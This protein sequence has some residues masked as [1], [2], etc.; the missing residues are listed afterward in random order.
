MA[1]IRDSEIVQYKD[2]K[3][4]LKQI[5][6]QGENISVYVRPGDEVD[7]NLNGINLQDLQYKLVG[8]D[9]I[10]DIPNQGSFTFVSM[11][12]M[13]YSDTPPFFNLGGATKLTL[14]TILSAIEEVNDLPLESVSASLQVKIDQEAKEDAP[15]V[16]KQPIVIIQEV[17]VLVEKEEQEPNENIGQFTDEPVDIPEIDPVIFT[18]TET[19]SKSSTE[20]ETKTDDGNGVPALLTFDIDIQHIS[21]TD[22][23]TAGVM[24]VE[25]G[26]GTSYDNFYPGTQAQAYKNG[27]GLVKQGD[28]EIIDYRNTTSNEANKL[29]INADDPAFFDTNIISREIVLSP[30]QPIGFGVTSVTIASDSFPVD[31]DIANSTSGGNSFTLVKDDLD[32]SVIEGF[33]F[34]ASGN[35][36]IKILMNKNQADQNFEF[37]IDIVSEFNMDN[38][39]EDLKSEVEDITGSAEATLEATK[40]YG[41]NVKNIPDANIDNPDEYYFEEFDDSN[42]DKIESG[43]VIITNDNDNIIY[44][45]KT[46]E[47]TINGGVANDLITTGNQNDTVDGRDGTDTMD[48]SSN[49][50]LDNDFGIDANL[51]TGI[52]TK[53]YAANNTDTVLNIENV[54]GTQDNDNIVGSADANVL[55]GEAGNDT[56]RGLAGSDT[57][58]G[59]AG[60]DTLEGGAAADSIN[61]GAGNDTASYENATGDVTVDLDNGNGNGEASGADGNDTLYN[62]ENVKGSAHDDT[63]TGD[64]GDNTLEGL[65]GDDH[66]YVSAGTDTIDGGSNG[67]NGD[68]ID[69]SNSS[70]AHTISLK[71]GQVFGEGYSS[72][73]GV[74]NAIGSAGKDIIVGNDDTNTLQGGINEDTIYGGAG[75]DFIYGG[76]Q[77]DTLSGGVGNDYINGGSSSLGGTGDVA[78]YSDITTGGVTVDLRIQDGTTSQNTVNAGNDTLVDIENLTGTSF[79]DTL[80]GDTNDNTLLGGSG[81]DTFIGNGST[82][83]GDFIDGEGGTDDLISFETATQ[84]ITFD[85]G[86][87]S[88]YQSTG[89]GKI[90]VQN[91]ENLKGGTGADTLY[92]SSQENKLYGHDGDDFLDGKAGNDTLYGELGDDTLTGGA[93]DDILDG[94]AGAD[95]AD[96]TANTSSGIKVDLT[97]VTGQVIDDGYGDTDTL[98]DIERVNG[99]NFTDTI[100]G[101][102]NVD[103]LYGMGGDDTLNGGLGSDTLYGGLGSDTADY[104]TRSESIKVDLSV[105]IPTV[106]VDTNSNSTFESGVDEEDTLNSI[107]NIIGGTNADII[108][109][110]SGNNTLKGNS[111]ADTLSGGIGTD[112]LD[113]GDDIDTIDFSSVNEDVTIDLSKTVTQAVYTD[114]Y[115]KVSNIENIIGGFGADKLTGDVQVNTIIG[116]DGADTLDGGGVSG[117]GTDSLIGGAGDDNFVVSAVGSTVYDG[118]FGAGGADVDTADFSKIANQSTDKVN[119]NLDSG[120][121]TLNG[122]TIAGTT[123]IGIEGAIGGSGDDTIT[124]TTTAN[125]LVGGAGD[126]TLLGNGASSGIDYIDGGEGGET[127]GDFVSFSY[128]SSNISVDLSNS[129]VQNSGDGNLIIQNI[130]NLEGGSGDDTLKGNDDD[131]I[132]R[133]LTG[134]DTLVGGKGYDTL[135]GG[136]GDIDIADYSSNTALGIKVDLTQAAQVTNDGYNNSD[137]LIDIEEIHGSNFTD[138]LVGAGDDD[139]FRGGAGDDTLSGASGADTLYG[140]AGN[141]VLKGGLGDDTLDGGLDN[142]TAD[143]SDRSEAIYG[144][145]SAATPNVIVDTDDANSDGDTT[146]EFDGSDEVDTLNAIENI[147]GGSN[148]DTLIGDANANTLSGG[149]G[150]DTLFGGAGADKLIG[151]DGSD[152]VSYDGDVSAINISL[153]TNQGIDGSGDTDSYNSIENVI[154]TS[155]DDTIEGDSSNNTLDG[156][157]GKDAISYANSTNV[158]G[159]TVNLGTQTASGVDEGTDTILNFEDILGGSGNDTL[160]GDGGTNTITGGSGNDTLDGAAGSDKLVGGLGSD[161]ASYENEGSLVNINLRA[162][163]G[164]DSSGGTDSY[165]SIEN[166]IGSDYDDTIEGNTA[167]NVLQGGL[168]NDT[169]TFENALSGVTVNLG[170]TTQQNTGSDGQDTIS[171]FENL[172]GSSSADNLTG[173]DNTNIIRGNG[174]DDSLSGG[175]GVDSLYGGAGNDTF[176]VELGDGDDIIDGYEDAQTDTDDSSNKDTLDYSLLTGNYYANVDLSLNSAEVTDGTTTDQTDTI[177][178]IENVIGSNQNDTL[179]GNAEVNTLSGSSG[180]DTFILKDG[181]TTGDAI[182]GGAHTIDGSGTQGST[183]AYTGKGDTVDYSAVTQSINLTLTNGAGTTNVQVGATVADHTLSGIENIIGSDSSDDTITGNTA[184]NTILGMAGNDTIDG[185]DGADILDGGFTDDGGG[186]N[187]QTNTISFASSTIGVTANLTTGITSQSDII[188]NFTNIIGTDEAAQVDILTGDGQDNKIEGLAGNDTIEGLDGDDNLLGGAGNDNFILRADDGEDTIDGG[189]GSG[190]TLD[191]SNLTSTQ[192]LEIEIDTST[193]KVATVREG[194]TT[195]TDDV[196]NIENITGGAGDDTITGDA[197]ENT[198]IG[199]AGDDILDGDFEDDKLYGG[200]GDDQLLGGLGDD[201]LYGE[202]GDDLLSGGA[203]DDII[204]GGETAEVSGDTIDYSSKATNL[205]LNLMNVVGGYATATLGTEKDSLA[206]IENIIGTINDDYIGGDNDSNALDGRAGADIIVGAGGDDVLSGGDDNDTFK[207]GLDN[208]VLAGQ[209]KVLEDGD[210]GADTIDGGDEIDTVDYS[211]ISQ[212]IEVT[213][214]GA[215]NTTV[216]VGGAGTGYADD[217]IKNVENVIGSSGND[218]INGDSLDNIL[219]G[220]AG[221]DTLYGAGGNDTLE[222]GTGINTADY[223]AALNKIVVDMDIAAGEVTADGDGGVDNLNNIQKIIATTN[224]DTIYGS[225]NDELFIGGADTDTLM[226]RGGDDTLY[227]GSFDGTNRTDSANDTV[228]YEYLTNGTD[229]VVVD[230]SADTGTAVVSTGADTDTLYDIENIIGGAGDDTIITRFDE[231]NIINGAA[232]SDTIDYSSLDTSH[233]ISVTLGTNGAQSTVDVSGT[234]NDDLVE[235][236]ENVTGTNLTDSIYGNNL[237]NTLLGLGGDDTLEGGAGDD[238]LDGGTDGANGDTA[239]YNQATGSVTVDLGKDNIAQ[240][241]GGGQGTDT[242]VDIENVIGSSY[243]DTFYTNFTEV[244]NFD[245]GIEDN[246]INGDTVDYSNLKADVGGANYTGTAN[247]DNIFLDLTSNTVEVR[248]GGSTVTDTISNIENIIATSG[249]DTLYGD[250]GD[251]TLKGLL[252]DDILDGGQGDDY[253]DGGVAGSDTAYYNQATSGVTVDLGL[254]GVAQA[255][256]GNQGTDTLV[257]IENVIGSKYNDTFKGDN[258]A[259]NIFNGGYVLATGVENVSDENDTVDYSSLT[260]ATDKIVVDLSNTTTPNV[261]VTVATTLQG[262]DTLI[263]IENVTGSFG[264]DTF[265][266]NSDSNV[267]LG[268]DGDDT[269][270]ITSASTG[271]EVDIINGGANSSVGDTVDFSGVTNPNYYV[272]VN[273]ASQDLLLKD[274]SNNIVRDDTVLN[275]ENITGTANEDIIIGDSSNNILDGDDGT[276]SISGGAGDDIIYGGANSAGDGVGVYETLDGGADN[277]TIYGGAGNDRILGGSGIGEDKLYGEAG[278][279]SITG[280]SGIDTIDGGADNDTIKG[281][282]GE[283]ILYGGTEDDIIYGGTEGDVIYGDDSLNSAANAGAD[284]LF[285]EDGTDTLFGG[286]GDDTLI[287]GANNDSL[288]GGEGTDTVDFST[289]GNGVTVD[290][291]AQTALGDGTD[292][293]NSIENAIGSTYDDNF[294]SDFAVSNRF[295]G[296]EG[297]ETTGDSISYAAITV[298]GGVDKVVVDLSSGADA[299]GYYDA[300][301]YQDGVITNTDKLKNMENITGSDGDDTI[302]GDIDNNTLTGLDGD[303][304]LSGQGGDDVLIGGAGSDTA[305]YSEKSVAVTV[306][307]KTNEATTA[308]ETDSLNSIENAIGGTA[309]DTFKMNEDTTANT[310]DG[311]GDEDTIS[312][313]YYTSEGVDVNLSFTG[314][315]TVATGDTD[316]IA[317]IEHIIG[318]SKNDTFV[319]TTASNSIVGG[320]GNDTFIAG[321]DTDNDNVIENVDDGADYIDGGVGTGDWAD[322]SSIGDDA[323]GATNGIE[324]TL[325]GANEVTATVNGQTGDDTLLN[326]ENISGTQDSDSIKGDVQNNTLLGNAGADILSGEAGMDELYGGDDADTLLGGAGD[327]ILMGDAGDDTLTGGVGSDN[328]Y[329]GDNSSDSGVDTVDYT[330]A[331]ES[332]TIDL[333]VTDAIGLTQ[334]GSEEGRSDGATGDQGQGVDNLYGIENVIGSNFAA[335][336]IYGS[337]EANIIQTQ[338]GDDTIVAAGA[339][340][341][342]DHYDGGVGTDTLDYSALS[343][344]ITIDLSV[345]ATDDFDGAGGNDSWS[346]SIATG[347][348]DIIKN[349]EN[350]IGGSGDDIITMNSGVNEIQG[351]AGSDT[352]SGNLGNDIINGYYE[353]QDEETDVG[354]QYDTVSYSYL[355]TKSVVL[356]LQLGTAYVDASDSDTLISIENAIGGAQGDTLTGSTLIN[357]LEGGAGDDTFVSSLG[358]DFIFGGNMASGTHTD[359]HI[360]GDTVDYSNSVNTNNK[361]VVDL[362]TTANDGNVYSN[363]QVLLDSDNSAV[364]TDRLYGIENISGTQNDDTLYGNSEANTLIGNSGD[365]T[366]KGGLG[367]DKLDG[368]AGD[369]IFLIEETDIGDAGGDEI[370]GGSGN[371]T[372]NYLGITSSGVTVNLETGADVTIGGYTHEFSG[373]EHI[374]GTNQADILTGDI[375]LNRIEGMGGDDTVYGKYGDDILDGGVGLDTLYGSDGLDTLYG[376]DDADKLYGG[377]GLDTIFGGAGADEIIF[378]AADNQNDIVYGGDASSDTSEDDLIDYTTAI[379]GMTVTLGEDNLLGTATSQDQGT[380]DIYGIEHVKGSNI[381]SDTIFGNSDVNTLYGQGADDTLYGKD[382][383]DH[384]LGGDQDDVLYGDDAIGN[385]D[386][387]AADTLDGGTGDDTLYGGLGDDELIGG[388]GDDIFKAVYTTDIFDGDDNIDGG[389]DSDTIDYSAVVDGQYYGNIDLTAGSVI[390]YD[391][392]NGDAVKKTDSITSIENA[393]GTSGDDTFKGNA[394]RNTLAGRSGADTVMYTFAALTAGIVADLSADTVDKVTTSGTFTDTVTQIENIV[395]TDF[396][397]VFVGA[398]GEVN[399]I[400]GGESTV[401]GQGNEVGGDTVDYSSQSDAIDVT[402]NGSTLVDVVISGDATDQ[403][404]NIE[405]VTG[406]TANDTIVGDLSVNTLLGMDGNDNLDGGAGND[407]IDGGA[408]DDIITG[409]A[410]IDTLYGGTGDDTFNQA[411]IADTGDTIDGGDGSDTVDYSGIETAETGG[412]YAD[413]ANNEILIDSNTDAVFDNSVDKVDTITSI[414][415]VSGTQNNDTLLGN[416]EVNELS[417]NGG[418]DYIDGAIG[419]DTLLGGLGDDEVYGGEGIDILYG[420]DIANSD[421]TGGDDTLSGGA[422]EDT[423]YGG[424]GDDTLIGGVNDDKLKGGEGSDTADY[425]GESAAVQANIA[426]SFAVGS[427]S[428]TDTFESIENITGTDLGGASDQITGDDASNTLK[429]LAGDDTISELAGDDEVVGGAGDD[430][431]YAGAGAD[432]IDGD[433]TD[434]ATLNGTS[435]TLDYS[436]INI[437]DDSGDTRDVDGTNDS[438]TPSSDAYSGIEIDLTVTT[439][440]RI[441]AQYGTDTVTNIENIV[442]SGKNDYIGGNDV[443]NTLEGRS[444]ND[445]LVGLDGADKLIGGDGIDT[446]DFSTGVQNVV[447]DMTRTQTDGSSGTYRVQNDGYGHQEYLDGVENITTGAGNDTIYGDS[448]S[449]TIITGAGNDTIRGGAQADVIEGG[450]DEDTVDFSDLTYGVTV[451]LDTDNNSGTAADGTA[452]SNGKTD[453]IREI[454]NVIGTASNDIIVA[455]EKDNTLIGADGDDTF[456][457]LEGVDYIDGGAGTNDTIDFSDG[458]QGIQVDL[459]AIQTFGTNTT[460]IVQDDGFG[461]KE[462]INGIENIIGTNSADT[463]IGDSAN[464]KFEGGSNDDTLYGDAGDDTLIGGTGADTFR[465]G[466]GN[467]II[468]GSDENISSSDASRDVIDYSDVNVAMTINLDANQ[469]SGVGQGVDLIYDIQDVLGSSV[470]DTITGI[471]DSVNSLMGQ[472]GDD[473][474]YATLDGDFIYGGSVNTTTSVHTDSGDDTVDYSAIDSNDGRAINVDL[475]RDD[476]DDTTNNEQEVQLV[477]DNTKFDNLE[478]IENIIGTQNNDIIKGS[479]DATEVNTLDGDKGD[480]TFFSSDGV[481]SFIGGEGI[482]TL[483]F[484]GVNTGAEGV[485]VDLDQDKAIDDGFGLED[486]IANDIEVVI[487]STNDDIL[488]GDSADNTLLG[489]DGADTIEGGSGADS[490]EGGVGVDTL[491]GD[492]GNDTILGGADGDFLYGGEG[493]D[494]LDGE[495]GDDTIYFDKGNDV[496][497]GGTGA[498][499]LTYEEQII[500]SSGI[501]VNLEATNGEVDVGADGIDNLQ[502]H[503]ETIIGTG[504]DDNFNG[505]TGS[506]AG[507]YV[508]TFKGL[509][510]NDVFSG[511][512]GDDYLDGGNQV[513]TLIFTNAQ[514]GVNVDLS[515]T[516]NL[517][518]TNTYAVQDDGFGDQDYV[519]NIENIIGTAYVDT[520]GGD[521]N[522][523]SIAAGDNDDT[524]LLSTGLDTL[525]GESGSDWISLENHEV[526]I[527]LLNATH[528]YAVNE[529]TTIQNI[530]NIIDST[531]STATR[532]MWGT[533]EGNIVI[534]YDGNDRVYG[535]D[536]DDVVDLGAGD[537]I[538]YSNERDATNAIGTGTDTLMGGAGTDIL[539]FRNDITGG[540]SA[541]IILQTTTFDSNFD[542]TNETTLT[543][544]TTTINLSGLDSYT[545][546]QNFVQITD[547][548]G[549]TDYIYVDGSGNTDFEQFNLSYA[550]DTFVGDDAVNIVNA[551]EGN[552]TI[553]GMGG[554]D[555]INGHNGNDKIYGGEGNDV[556]NAGNDQDTIIGGLGDDA[557]NGGNGNDIIYDDEGTDTIDG[558]GGTDTVIFKDGGNGITIDLTA[559]TNNSIDSYGNTQNIREVENVTSTDYVDTITTNSSTNVILAGAQNDTIF[560]STGND[561]INGEGGTDLL[562]YSNLTTSVRLELGDNARI[563]T[564]NQTIT[565]IENARGSDYAD[566]ITGESGVNTLWGGDDNDV[567]DGEA[568]NDTLYGDDGDDTLI[569]GTGAD[570]LEGGANSAYTDGST[571]TGD[572]VDYTDIGAKVIIDLNDSGNATAYVTGDGNDTLVGIENLTGSAVGDELSGNIEANTLL[573]NAG[574]DILDGEAGADYIDAGADNDTIIGGI[575]DDNLRGSTGDDIFIASNGDGDDVI[576][577]GDNSDIVDYSNVTGPLNVTLGASGDATVTIAGTDTLT[578]IEGF[579]GTSS[580][581]SLTGNAEDNV[582]EGRDGSDILTGNDG[583]DTLLGGE[584]DDR[585]LGGVGNDT[586]DGGNDGA[587]GD[588]IDYSG[589]TNA[590]NINLRA[591]A[592]HAT[593]EGTDQISGIEHIDVSNDENGNVVQGDANDNSFVAGIGEDSLSYDG[594]TDAVTIDVDAGTSSGDGADV[595]V[596]FENFIGSN[597]NDILRNDSV[598]DDTNFKSFDGKSGIDTADYTASSQ[599]ITVDLNGNTSATLTVAGTTTDEL[600]NVEIIKTGSGDDTFILTSTTGLDTLDAGGGT[601]T[602]EL[603]GNLDLSNVTLLNFETISIEDGETLTLS[604]TDL[605]NQTMTIDMVGT[606]SLIIEATALSSDH[607]FD[608][609]TINRGT[610]TVTLQVDNSVDLTARDINGAN[611]FTIDNILVNS[612]TVTLT[613]AQVTTGTVVLSG[614][615]SAVVEVSG[616]SA[617]D[618]STI[619]SLDSGSSETIQFTNNST[620]SGDFGDS[621]IVVDATK[622]LTTTMGKLSGKTNALSG[623]GNVTLSDVNVDATDVNSVADAIDGVVTATVTADT[624]TN[625]ATNLTNATATDALSLTVTDAVTDAADLVTLNG[626]TNQQIDV[627]AITSTIHGDASELIDIYVTNVTQYNGLGNEAVTIDDTT[628]AVNVDTIAN[629]T[630]GVLTATILTGAVATT[631]AAITHVDTNDII[632]FTTNDTSVDATDLVALNAKVDTFGVGTITTITEAFGTIGASAVNITDALGIAANSNVTI[633]GGSISVSDT[634]II[635]DATTAVVTAIVSEGDA[636]T[637]KTLT[638]DN[639]DM[640][641]VTMAAASTQASDLSII[642]GKTGVAID[643]T[644]ITELTGDATDVKTLLSSSTI[645]TVTDGSLAVTVS[646][647]T[648]VSDINTI[649]SDSATGVV[650]ATAV[651][652]D[653]TTLK[654]L[655]TTNADAITITMAASST[656]AA[657]LITIEG[658]TSEAIDAT[659]ITALTGNVAD[660]KTALASGEITTVTNNTLGVTLSGTTVAAADLVTIDSDSATGTINA[661]SFTTISG[662][663]SDLNS[664]YNSGNFTNLGNEN[665]TITDTGTITSTDLNDLLTETS[666]TISL[667]S[668]TIN[669]VSGD[670]LD[671]SSINSTGTVTINDSTGN[672]DITGTSTDD[673]LNLNSGNDTVNLG[674]GNDTIKV[675]IADLDIN[676]NITDTSGTDNVTFNDSGT[677]DSADVIDFSGIETLNMYSGDDTVTFDDVSEFDNFRNELDVVDSGGTDTLKF[678]STSVT[679]DLNF[680]NLD[681]FENLELSSTNDDVTLS[682]DEPDNIYGLGGD[683]SFT[684]DYSNVSSFT[685]IDGGADVDEVIVQGTFAANNTDFGTVNDY[686]NIETLDISGMSLTGTDSDEIQFTGDLINEWTN[687]GAVSGALTLQLTADQMENIGYTDSGSTY[688]SSVSD[689]VTYNLENGATLTIEQVV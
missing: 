85:L 447:I 72:I 543:A 414:E 666:G 116:G 256:G 446:A 290:L 308:T 153:K 353:A 355:S 421:V 625:L 577:G 423:I 337:S 450:A 617:T 209:D 168:G 343:E 341:G 89:A 242:L 41:A 561:N 380:D 40:T 2:K 630:T 406:S 659:S 404:K 502:D 118:S 57:L 635:A 165:D 208:N 650:T 583:D 288:Y 279:D 681:E 269:F 203:G 575:G 43:F 568:S 622:T 207:A 686:D 416:D 556:I 599:D 566:E 480:D 444:G 339:S 96:Y 393:I 101:S 462:Y 689:G 22:S 530:E 403:I 33:T 132:L 534:A 114:A 143:Y 211:A 65:A 437:S 79:D 224:K 348:S 360:V 322:Y 636:T 99:S 572:T 471:T 677:I 4:Q 210:D 102:D 596:D 648:S 56:L 225:N 663:L 477:G 610:G 608:N 319:G 612:G 178:N 75:D 500:T 585:L 591:D 514:N 64:S 389:A 409:G 557:I 292:E 74:E 346:V 42:G 157:T 594:S 656:A 63:I 440:Q 410:G 189:E 27:A 563:G 26:G 668:V 163:T 245:G 83:T 181:I 306:D 142:D 510:G 381:E 519:I 271:S 305:S 363:A 684:L 459:T 640:I 11:A 597:Q 490:L 205:D 254:D 161:T 379:K 487:G 474:F 61:G 453:I 620:F 669:V 358:D 304:L 538:V 657:D 525:N 571:H 169:L 53:K 359:S 117:A 94:G 541:S 284:T 121:F 98:I 551:Y 598:K 351:G 323:N 231:V 498:D 243:D 653:A 415:N 20:D 149:L 204:V 516:Q 262:S 604:A 398:S 651:E 494:I 115:Y 458:T 361:L 252:G 495:A 14:N 295:D 424:Y 241:I 463:I 250:S 150:D 127:N 60:N 307:F 312:Y 230:L 226:G 455:D 104:S 125:S 221:D 378:E 170:T 151:G 34:D 46:L 605:D 247:A 607:D 441:H 17:E 673:I 90:K 662:S 485:N 670:T 81:N 535:R 483:D 18:S 578:N 679:G 320:S 536:G 77:D 244:N 396:D 84:N 227:G 386:D 613:E 451:D 185:G 1:E 401:N 138:T 133:G 559:T 278:D 234:A 584:G 460:Y 501:I 197:F 671:L 122:N 392:A 523:N 567:I 454:E 237:N 632:T 182:I 468:Y 384:L 448:N 518:D 59:G 499:T 457:G 395:G 456:V 371:D 618:F 397:D 91:V 429:G 251:N 382:G 513:D 112:Y 402:L 581:D 281:D 222:G 527:D 13:G 159:V 139:T 615:G 560:G 171:G 49:D 267:F 253:L 35:L 644:N 586:I 614:A 23:T 370:L 507:D 12:L 629:K 431:I 465:A 411:N 144:N 202:A 374:I 52:I 318:S 38:V 298:D 336:I 443:A 69:A 36:I 464:N 368:G 47:N 265:T 638:T 331:L 175:L 555:I 432:I 88:S 452:S 479:D 103:T 113:G 24:S 313:E 105:A 316:T 111:G 678:G 332:L 549:N 521:A 283:D 426:N 626:K 146:H 649:N 15:K 449:N 106:I 147:T 674:A 570:R 628:T 540:Q 198:L 475:S 70:V 200:A 655:N 466:A 188:S 291:D 529:N 321:V 505:Y 167:N 235:N 544:T 623:T 272:D 66:F 526:N 97:R 688:Q 682:G 373:I 342:I 515:V 215:T 229:K 145:L 21:A 82:G 217:T 37:I 639:T 173:D 80:I 263:N 503:I 249:D 282:A 62:I 419:D 187:L 311:G 654:T 400:D 213:L 212:A 334:N 296:N 7:F 552:D 357:S 261:A 372:L 676:D 148:S 134:S 634:S 506:D 428:G 68:T 136:V 354:I 413:L 276:D 603:S 192:N 376:G 627:T 394:E 32:T 399:I 554:A 522:D 6:N 315:Q 95:I 158:S 29:I 672:E 155:Y 391:G 573:G 652:H 39:P 310:I 258:V 302:T 93:G 240:A 387:G 436:L 548:T 196:V 420:D 299:Q 366:L 31:F 590:I 333:D 611:N 233:S 268:A 86:D 286:Y 685:T 367:I 100:V 491:K 51:T 324:V 128:S 645:T 350:I 259:S 488:K 297:T 593:G 236:I 280:G 665:I 675:D 239:Y 683:D 303:D 531:T 356:D 9:I 120:S 588:W 257:S 524:L 467:D 435:D 579:Y 184:V 427:S 218:I 602:L 108:I 469:A 667:G 287:G 349:I 329:G 123:F 183:N 388:T 592:D 486:Y 193:S 201:E 44:G 110:N 508:D 492:S 425:S 130:E 574:N 390:I 576:D 564:D 176:K 619:L 539:E 58:D 156:N 478:G 375:N 362:T 137:T 660:V 54:T 219:D 417:G 228:S 19:K 71:D 5:P 285:G 412:I 206:E 609:I 481:D 546:D 680:N 275:I 325:D 433:D 162:G 266:G 364:Y 28:A 87:S 220:S 497:T 405:N 25:G 273:L 335:D 352:L 533:H 511:G 517:A 154:G 369:D 180:D 160:I 199:N 124:G 580:N 595:F 92:G 177:A 166:V 407:Y 78:T 434:G 537:D 439:A 8:G 293:L 107:E 328:L 385:S 493:N 191:Y 309:K 260:G 658:K 195:Y 631:L 473:I 48:Y 606:G 340:D 274:A 558:D 641:T 223:T 472:S 255:V 489:N 174:G 216:Y 10:I 377:L 50:N 67:A 109:G 647:T 246:E 365:D 646:G 565:S 76:T 504:L 430:Y 532:Y 418:D 345:A 562:D 528:S 542:F 600:S 270:L 545:G 582:F 317:N 140:E 461:N 131:N 55:L 314:A 624:A 301:I 248:Y 383:A 129:G 232:G 547:G 482:D 172:T 16:E 509:A 330:N 587:N 326:I 141:D 470:N 661:S 186:N 73:T 643:A 179:T 126:D 190:D 553:L 476:G 484:R 408:G 664:V 496:I 338:A 238:Y 300:D 621:N 344:D 512:R 214:N 152:T 3:V 616:N 438:T 294:I 30:N 687:G 520:L 601:D 569:G 45:S 289:T 277:D 164:T 119:V 442:G 550:G 642:D 264:N 633:T 422:G 135:D 194:A 347:D 445:Y 327:D 589:S 637:L